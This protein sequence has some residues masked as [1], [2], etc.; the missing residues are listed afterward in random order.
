VS[1]MVVALAGVGA[2]ATGA[3]GPANPLMVAEGVDRAHQIAVRVLQSVGR[4][5]ETG[6]LVLRAPPMWKRNSTG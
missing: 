5:R 4:A 2:L 1:K 6:V 3:A